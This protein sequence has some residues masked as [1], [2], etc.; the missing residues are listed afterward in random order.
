[1]CIW[2]TYNKAQQAVP[3]PDPKD[4]VQLEGKILE[5]RLGV[6]VNQPR[7]TARLCAHLFSR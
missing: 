7:A 6:G 3:Q 1:M 2:A 5:V 4:V